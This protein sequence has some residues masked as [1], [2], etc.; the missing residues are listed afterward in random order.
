M[1]NEWGEID[2][3]MRFS[4]NDLNDVDGVAEANISKTE[5]DMRY[6]PTDYGG[7]GGRRRSSRSLER[8]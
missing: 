8:R 5:A 2:P 3:A 4:F 1:L 7:S 6:G